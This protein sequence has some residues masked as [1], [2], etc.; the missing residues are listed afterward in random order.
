MS[1]ELDFETGKAA[2]AFVGEVPWHGLG[3]RLQDGAGLSEWQVAAGLDWEART[4]RVEYRRKFVDTKGKETEVECVD[5]DHKVIYRSD[6]GR[7]LSI[8][9]KK[10]RPVQPRQ[11][12]E[13]YRDLTEKHGFVMETAGSLKQGR[14]IWALAKSKLTMVI[15]G[16]DRVNAYL[17]LATSFDGSMST[18]ARATGIRVVCNNTISIATAGTPDVMVPH[19]TDFDADK[20]KVD[21]NIGDAWVEFEKRAN[22][23]AEI[24]VDKSQTLRFMLDVYLG[25]D[26]KEKVE[27]AM[28]DEKRKKQIEK[29]IERFEMRLHNGPG[30][31]LRSA[32]DTAWGLLNAVTN[33]VDFSYPARTQENRLNSAWFGPGQQ[34]KQRAMKAALALVA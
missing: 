9:H 16:Q 25:L 34:L 11:I 20:I 17:L 33:D 27:E 1:H 24:Q 7:V 26:N 29:L 13:F 10:Y 14:K 6:S 32:R 3:E 28:G 23:L 31:T 30:A 19:S 21:L 18:Q 12:I 2:I 8:M 4:A 22:Q 5:E 15:K